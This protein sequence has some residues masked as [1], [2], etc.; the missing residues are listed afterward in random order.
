MA[1][2]TI[3]EIEARKARERINAYLTGCSGL[4]LISRAIIAGL[5]LV[6]LITLWWRG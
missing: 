3:Q 2:P 4:A 6:I 1:G 5:L